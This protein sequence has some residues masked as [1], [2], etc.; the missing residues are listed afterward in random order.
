MMPSAV[1]VMLS[2]GDRPAAVRL[3]RELPSLTLFE[4]AALGAL[5]QV[6]ERCE[7]DAARVHEYSDTGVTPL[8]LA[9]FYGNTACVKDLLRRGAN[10]GAR[11]RDGSE[12]T[13]LHSACAG[14]QLLAAMTL[15]V[16]GAD[17]NAVAD[18]G[19]RPLETAIRQGN[20]ELA[21]CLKVAG[22]V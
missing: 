6:I 13:P 10:L 20:L 21:D 4:A 8:H 3:A 12:M 9:A 14:N 17:V 16:A 11:T 15:I 5:E 2:R 1:L 18:G 22:A 19:S 7:E